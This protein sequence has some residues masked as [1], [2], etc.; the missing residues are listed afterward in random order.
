ML[1]YNIKR[2]Y[3]KNCYSYL[4]NTLGIIA[5]SKHM[6]KHPN[7]LSATR[8]VLHRKKLPAS[9]MPEKGSVNDERKVM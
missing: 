9:K 6:V 3:L 5:E 1:Q 8:P 4:T 7:L 2:T